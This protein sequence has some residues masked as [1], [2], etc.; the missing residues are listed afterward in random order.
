MRLLGAHSV[1]TL[2]GPGG[3]GKTRLALDIAA[4]SP[5]LGEAVVV[6]L[7]V[8][9]RADRVCQAV[10]SDLGLRT[11]GE[12]R[13]GPGRRSAGRP[14]AAPRPGQLR[15]RGRGVPRAGG[16]AAARRA[17]RTRAR[18][19]AGHAAGA[20]RV[21]RPAAAA[22]RCPRD[23]T[24]LAALRRQPGVRAFVEHARRRRTDFELTRGG[25]SGPGRGAA[26]PGRAAARDRAGRAAGGGDAVAS[27]PGTARPGSGP[28]HRAAGSRGRAAADA[29]GDHRLVV[30]PAHGGRA[31]AAPGDR[32][33]RR[34]R[35]PGDRR[36]PR[37][38]DAGRPARPPASPGRLVTA[39]GGRAER[40]LPA[41]VHR[42][43]LPGRR[44]RSGW[45]RPRRHSARFVERCRAIAE[46]IGERMLGPD[47]AA[48]DRRLRAELDNLRSARDL[49]P[50][51]P[52]WRSRWR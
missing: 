22:A 6:P 18:D 25:G 29:A 42:A 2:T 36:G 52:G 17:R 49:A 15:A 47:E 16:G 20:G 23:A 12:A 24:D 28:L 27:G 35:R 51:M 33:L 39:G 8:V 4:D 5:V 11:T 37:R 31:V 13:P 50:P 43:C 44:D 21:R 45:A 34:R 3:V 7:A 1:V 10:A 19:V 46:D 32:P 48:T 41:A 9:D 30:P 14:G 26:A 38:V 40:A